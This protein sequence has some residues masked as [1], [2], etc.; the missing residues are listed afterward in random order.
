MRNLLF[1]LVFISIIVLGCGGTKSPLENCA[2]EGI[3]RKYDGIFQ[4]KK[5]WNWFGEI[6]KP[7]DKKESDLKRREMTEEEFA[8][9]VLHA[10]LAQ[11]QAEKKLVVGTGFTLEETYDFLKKS[12]KE[13]MQNDDYWYYHRDCEEDRE[14]A[15]KTF[16]AKYQ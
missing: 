3:S 1:V 14:D 5:F 9:V 10:R 4:K 2:D 15:P 16:D 6:L 11:A 13:K 8:L 12:Y 7:L